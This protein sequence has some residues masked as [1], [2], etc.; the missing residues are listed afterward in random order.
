MREAG[1]LE[2]TPGNL[3]DQYKLGASH[4]EGSEMKNI[5]AT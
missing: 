4:T 1:G 2:K 3:R 5:C